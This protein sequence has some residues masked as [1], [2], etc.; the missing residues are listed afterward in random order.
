[1]I[2]T[3][4]G[5][6]SSYYLGIEYLPGN[7]RT[8]IEIAGA[9]TIGKY[10][11]QP[12]LLCFEYDPTSGKYGLVIMS[13]LKLAGGLTVLAVVMFWVVSYLNGRTPSDPPI[14]T[15]TAS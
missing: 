4:K 10:L 2:L 8:A 5:K 12:T 3:P 13:A 6:V 11:K 9:G 1:M 15:Q 14:E 7:L